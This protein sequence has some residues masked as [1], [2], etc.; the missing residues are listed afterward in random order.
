MEKL[1]SLTSSR[2][3]QFYIAEVISGGNRML[4]SPWGDKYK[5]MRKLVNFA[6]IFT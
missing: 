5:R 2:P 4:L 6:I 1:G 3:K